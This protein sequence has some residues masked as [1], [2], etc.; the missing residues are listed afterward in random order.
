L[1]FIDKGFDFSGAAGHDKIITDNL[2]NRFKKVLDPLG[3]INRIGNFH[4][5]ASNKIEN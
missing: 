4:Q 5:S 3:F 1:S 2:M